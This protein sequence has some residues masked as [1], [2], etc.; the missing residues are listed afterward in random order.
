M[1]ND[2]YEEFD[3]DCS[4]PI[5]NLSTQSLRSIEDAKFTYTMAN[6]DQLSDKLR[7]P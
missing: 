5:L 2:H 3:E 7:I 1:P 4:A 6:I